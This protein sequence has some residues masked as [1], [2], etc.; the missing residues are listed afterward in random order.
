VSLSA[1]L[2][3]G[4]M[5]LVARTPLPLVRGFGRAMGL[6]LHTLAR[7]RRHVVDVNLALCF[8]DKSPQERRQIARDT[9]VHVAQA[10]LDRGWLWHAPRDVVEQRIRLH[11]AMHEFEGDA[12]TIVFAPHFCGLDA[13]GTALSIAVP[14]PWTSIFT[15]QRDPMLNDW[16]EAGRTRF[17]QEV[18]VFDR[19]AGVK[20]IVSGLRK[21]GLLYLLPDMNFGPQES[22]FVP[23]Y[24][25]PAAT[26]PSLSRFARLGRAK[27]VPVLS[28]LTQTGYDIEALPAWTNFPTDDVQ[29]DTALMN[30]RLAG[31]IDTMPSQ[32]YWVHRR[33]KTRPPGQAPVY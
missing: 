31:W 33:F 10:F 16:L 12:P 1:T 18:Q 17:H 3:I 4:F 9:F 32:Y 25:V 20:P 6:A 13:G 24:G 26:V 23:F 5:R 11:G 7:P 28:K 8:P 22:I 21:G 14:R 29:A 15:P 30:E 27:I 19:T 2:G